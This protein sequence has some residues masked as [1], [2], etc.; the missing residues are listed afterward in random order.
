MQP[1]TSVHP[2]PSQSGSAD[3]STHGGSRD[4]RVPLKDAVKQEIG[5]RNYQLW[6]AGKTTFKVQHDEL[7][8]GVASP[9]LLN[10]MQKQFRAPITEVARMALG[11]S[12]RVSFQ[13]DSA[14]TF[15]HEDK[16]RQAA[17]QPESVDEAVK[18]K[19]EPVKSRRRFLKLHDF[20]QG[21]CNELAV[22]A[23]KQVS[24]SPGCRYNP[25]F[26]HGGV[27]TGKTHLL[28]GIYSRVRQQFPSLQVVYLTSEA[29]TNYFT[30]ALRDRTLPSF[31]QRF[32]N[33]D[34]LLVD[35]IDFLDGKRVIQEEFLHTFKQ[36]ASHNRQIVLTANKHP[37]LLNKLSDEL[38]TRFLSGMVCRLE[39]PDFETRLQ[40][41]EHKA[42]QL[43]AE[44]TPETLQY[45]AQ[46][47]KN[48]VREL[49]GALNS[50]QAYHTM[51][52]R[53]VGINAARDILSELERDC[54]R[55]IRLAD[56]EK[57]VCN[58]FGVRKEELRSSTRAR[59]ISQPRMLAMYLARKHTKAA[60]SEIGD[61]FGGRNHS[62]VVSAEKKVRT[63]LD[64]QSIINIATQ[65]WYMSD[66]VGTLEQ[67]L[68]AS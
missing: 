66:V 9:F 56:I 41:V 57:V 31:R 19:P 4:E 2:N 64:E 8:I 53:R 24:D 11:P 60:Y 67:Q 51:T 36:L 44:L 15:R 52:Q 26:L 16:S 20:I 22:M 5:D 46:R 68:M 35:D 62:T 37:R 6:F 54:I 30:Q 65:D 17:V 39:S 59:R 32:R 27:G 55:I 34:V 18:S 58:L 3:R 29:F 13:V 7:S 25:L 33:V 1:Y 23:S 28:E 42:N 40:I 12:A 47:F 38:T 43:S 49:E 21:R 14:I 10:W 45:V 50:L 48:N 63:W 61:Y